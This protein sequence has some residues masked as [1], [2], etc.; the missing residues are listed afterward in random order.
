MNDLLCSRLT[1]RNITTSF[2]SQN[3]SCHTQNHIKR[4]EINTRIVSELHPKES[5]FRKSKVVWQKCAVKFSPL[6]STKLCG[7][8]SFASALICIRC[9]LKWKSSTPLIKIV[10]TTQLYCIACITYSSDIYYIHTTHTQMG[11]NT[12]SM[13]TPCSFFV[14]LATWK[15]LNEHYFSCEILSRNETEIDN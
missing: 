13:A 3:F 2:L 10:C 5:Y 15:M 7:G 1:V 12:L 11:L 4:N 6:H 9:Q 8:A 14:A